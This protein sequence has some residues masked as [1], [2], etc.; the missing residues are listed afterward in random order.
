MAPENQ[1]RNNMNTSNQTLRAL[2]LRPA[3]AAA[4][5]A[6]LIATS[7]AQAAGR[8]PNPGVIPPDST[9]RG[10]T[11]GEW[12]ALWWQTIFAVPIVNGDHPFFSGGAFGEDKGVVFLAAIGGGAI[13][14]ETI[15][16]GAS[17]FFP[18]INAECSVLEPD[19]FHGDNEAELRACANDHI[20]HTSGLFATID[21]V[22]VQNLGAYRVE[23]P[24]FQFGP[25]P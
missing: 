13:I 2:E 3:L 4:A 19:P 17:L 1:E 5:L 11:Y 6:L 15:P 24:L 20:D 21:G 22:A 25:L 10:L 18:V 14:D 12:G 7:P 23:S 16:A 8:N 9:Y